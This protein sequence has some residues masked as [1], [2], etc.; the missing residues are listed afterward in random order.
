MDGL[1][2]DIDMWLTGLGGWAYVAAPTVMA[3]VSILPIPAE[4]PAMANGALF[5]PVLGTVITWIGAM[6]GAWIS[7]E[8]A[9][10]WGRPVAERMMS[11]RALA[12]VDTVAD[13]AGW[14]G[15]LML[16][17]IPLVAFTAV[18]WGSGLSRVPRWRFVWTTAIGIAP[19][20]I[21]FTSSGAGL[22]ALYRRSPPLAAGVTLALVAVMMLWAR[23]R[24]R[25]AAD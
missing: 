7:Y 25:H 2:S 10:T 17:L 14:S 21:L 13:A 12:R 9:R 4:A 24:R 5:G 20:A 8:I 11:R 15:L 23:R 22:G 19:G 18:N 6:A 1:F 3:A 16:R